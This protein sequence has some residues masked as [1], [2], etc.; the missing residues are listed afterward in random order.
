MLV[1]VVE[2]KGFVSKLKILVLHWQIAT[3]LVLKQ[4]SWVFI[5]DFE[6]FLNNI[7]VEMM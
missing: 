6:K 5:L 1:L 7:A 3:V 4:R 2:G